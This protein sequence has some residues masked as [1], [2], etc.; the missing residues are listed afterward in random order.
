MYALIDTN[1]LP[2]WV[3]IVREFRGED[4]LFGKGKYEIG[5]VST[6]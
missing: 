2:K 1:V 6:E 4:N 3:T 5:G